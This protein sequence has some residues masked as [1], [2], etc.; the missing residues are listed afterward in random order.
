MKWYQYEVTEVVKKT[1]WIEA[2]SEEEAEAE[3]YEADLEKNCDYID[4][5]ITLL[6]ADYEE[7]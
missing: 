6:E 7:H 5:Q 1:V 4:R 3:A 2:D